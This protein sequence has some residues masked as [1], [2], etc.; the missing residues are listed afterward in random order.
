MMRYI[1]KFFKEF[2]FRA[3]VYLSCSI[4]ANACIFTYALIC[5]K[6]YP[7]NSE[8]Y[9]SQMTFHLLLLSA[10]AILLIMHYGNMQKIKANNLEDNKMSKKICLIIALFLFVQGL[11][12]IDSSFLIYINKVPVTAPFS[13]VLIHA[14]YILIRVIVSLMGALKYREPSGASTFLRCKKYLSRTESLFLVVVAGNQILTITGLEVSTLLFIN[15]IT[16]VLVGIYAFILSFILV[17]HG[18]KYSK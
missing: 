3:A 10:R 16:G 8:W 4:F 15:L 12:I 6:I 2:N 7:N 11:Q 9:G 1:V 14:Y 18:V 17:Y 5:A 13:F